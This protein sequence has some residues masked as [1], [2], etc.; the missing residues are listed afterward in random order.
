MSKTDEDDMAPLMANKS[1]ITEK[2]KMLILLYP[3]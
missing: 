3:L 1:L 2:Q